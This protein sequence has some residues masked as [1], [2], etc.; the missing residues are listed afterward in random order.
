MRAGWASK[1][2]GCAAVAAV[3]GG[4]RCAA[5]SRDRNE[6]AGRYDGFIYFENYAPRM[7]FFSWVWIRLFFFFFFFFF[8]VGW[9]V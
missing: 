2:K 4:V 8:L 3:Y 5:V 1:I 9:K 6:R 7:R